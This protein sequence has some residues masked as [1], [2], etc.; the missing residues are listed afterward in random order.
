MDGS[1]LKFL[2]VFRRLTLCLFF[3]GVSYWSFSQT[4]AAFSGYI[5]DS[6]TGQSLS[7]VSILLKG[8]NQ[9]TS[10]DSRGHFVLDL[11]DENATLEFSYIGY[12]TLKV[13]A[14]KGV[15]M[16]IRLAPMQDSSG[17]VVVVAYGQQKK[18]SMVASITTVNPKELRGATSNMTQM[19]AG[20]IA[21]IISYQQS[22]APGFDNASFFVR[23]VASFGAGKVDPLILIDGIESSNNDLARLQPDDIAGFSVLKDAAASSLYGARGANGVI[24][25]TTKNGA[26][27]KVQFN[28]RLEM[29]IS[30][31]TQNFKFADNVTYMK[32][33]NESVL[34]RDPLGQLPYTQEKIDRTAAGAD[35]LR[36]PNNNWIDQLIKDYTINQKANINASGGGKVAKY[37]ISGTY[38]IDNGVL[39]KVSNST[40]NN[41][42]KLG[43]Y[44]V[45]SNVTINVTP[46][47]KA[48][49]RTY[50]Q[51]DKYNGPNGYVDDNNN[52]VNGGTNVFNSAIW[53]NP[54]MFPAYYPSSFAPYSKHPLFGNNLIPGTTK[55]YTNPFAKMVS[56]YDEYSASTVNV[57]F[58]LAQDLKFITKGLSTRFMAYTQRYNYY[59]FSRNYSPFYYT[60]YPDANGDLNIL[61]LLNPG[62]GTE[63]LSYTE[64]AKIVN[65]AAYGEW[66]FNYN[67]TFSKKH[68]VTG[69][70]IGILQNRTSGNAGDLQTSLPE[71]NLGVSG[72]VTYGYDDRYLGEFDFG[73]NGSERFAANHRFGFFPSVGLGWHVSN[74]KFFES[75]KSVV[76]N[77]KFRATYGLVGNDQIGD[78]RDRFFYLSNVNPNDNGNGNYWGLNGSHFVPGYSISRYANPEITWEIAK[79]LN[80]G[81]DLSFINGIDVTVDAYHSVRS[82]ILMPRATIPSTMGLE[83][84]AYA[85]VGKAT[86]NGVDIAVNYNKN[87]GKDMWLQARGNITFASNK[88]EVYEEPNYPASEQYL[89]H[90]NQPISQYYGFIAERLFVDDEEAKNSPLQNFG[91]TPVMGG[92]IKYRDVNGDGQITDLDK[93][94]IGYPTTPEI[95]YGFGFSFGYKSFDIS[96]FFQGNARVSFFINPDN[97]SPFVLNQDEGRQNGLLELIANDHWSEENQNLHAFWP[98]LDNQLNKNNDQVSTWW[99]QDGT[100]LRFKTLE[101]GYTF[102]KHLLDKMHFSNLRLYLNAQNLAL[103]SKFKLWDPEMDGNGLGYPLQAL[104]NFGVNFGL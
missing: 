10:S 28:G 3:I 46:T 104:Y 91:G 45:R 88:Y 83:S 89:S 48:T 71:R 7:G 16:N 102:P 36:Y 52:Y 23:G 67:R 37:Y 17:D 18:S 43:N 63:Y 78:T 84:T 97:I 60:L 87:F 33:A 53:S 85:N 15:P 20:R 4:Q 94:P 92:D 59:L 13:Q 25:V 19:L 103:W 64:G 22:G 40:F 69:M 101:L 50:A 61:S 96:A 55:M 9:G 44:N 79:T 81:M 21:G 100:F 47:T 42:M 30:T 70:V 6:A 8:T 95:T 86:G 56:G 14:H 65:S 29:P 11:G 66:A 35:P 93:V 99:L 76:S 41:N 90:V 57:Q 49:V 31:N 51:F 80:Y 12:V 27:G 74:E 82:N 1:F 62:K 77:L 38:N 32:L 75:I 98:R 24:L 34:T 2:V 73:Y 58:E 54:V 68:E 26:I 72:R 39:K 5:I